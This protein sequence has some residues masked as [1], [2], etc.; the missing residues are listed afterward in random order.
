MISGE[1]DPLSLGYLVACHLHHVLKFIND[2]LYCY[3][4]DLDLTE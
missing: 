3:N 2:V 4:T 1:R